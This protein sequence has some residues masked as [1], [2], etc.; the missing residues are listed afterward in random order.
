MPNLTVS[1]LDVSQLDAFLLDSQVLS[2]PGPPGSNDTIQFNGYGLQ[3]ANITVQ[4]IIYSAPV[5]DLGERAYPRANGEYMEVDY[6]RKTIISM[7]GM[8]RDVSQTALEQR[9]DALRQNLSVPNGI[10][11]ITFAG[12]TRIWNAYAVIERIFRK[13]EHFHINV[14]PWEADF[15]CIQPFGRASGKTS[16]NP[17]S[18]AVASPT[19]YQMTNEGSASSELY[20]TF[21]LSVVGAVTSLTWT[22]LTTGEAITISGAFVNGDTLVIDGETRTVKLN[23]V[24]TDYTGIFPTLTPGGNSLQLT[25]NG[26]GFSIIFSAGF[27]FRYL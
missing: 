17:P 20:A 8:L 23:G 19:V 6:W 15:V 22:N 4:Q 11:Q 3:N 18:A 12:V 5:R 27:Y 10:L 14:C 1:R 16:I 9:M 13:R 26:G 24:S 25:T 2:P 21:V 7:H